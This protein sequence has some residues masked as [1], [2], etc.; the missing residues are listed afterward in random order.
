M[1]EQTQH[2]IDL[3]KRLPYKDQA[4]MIDA[5]LQNMPESACMESVFD[6]DVELAW[7]L[8]IERRVAESDAGDKPSIPFDAAWKRI[9]GQND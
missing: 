9:S 1:T 7:Q 4:I 6:A 5:L 2:V 3:A 8:E